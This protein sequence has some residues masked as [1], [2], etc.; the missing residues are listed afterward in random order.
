VKMLIVLCYT[1]S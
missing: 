1:L